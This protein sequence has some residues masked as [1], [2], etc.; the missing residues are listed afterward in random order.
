LT[1]LIKKGWVIAGDSDA[2]KLKNGDLPLNFSI[3]IPTPSIILFAFEF[4][5]L[6]KLQV[7]Q[8]IVE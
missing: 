8:S 3:N 6:M 1:Q 4:D 2:L 5:V 7:L